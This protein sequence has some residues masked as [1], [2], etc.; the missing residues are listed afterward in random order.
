MTTAYLAG[1]QV[2]RR[3]WKVAADRLKAAC[4]KYGVEGRFPMDNQVDTARAKPL[5]AADIRRQNLRLIE[6]SDIVL[7]DVHCFRGPNADDGTAFEVGY[8]TALR[9][10]VL[11]Y[12]SGTGI[13]LVD[14]VH[15]FY[16]F[17]LELQHIRRGKDINGWAV[18][19]FGLP[20]NLMLVDPQW[21]GVHQSIEDALQYWA[22]HKDTF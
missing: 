18:E 11:C 9:K 15:N 2:F 12:A 22:K 3:D 20:V 4:R 10:P 8:A 5:V 14:K 6:R 21:G 7:A 19:D 16:Q 17:W 1:P 13:E